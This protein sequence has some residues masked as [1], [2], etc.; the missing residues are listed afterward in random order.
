MSDQLPLHQEVLLLALN[1]KKG[2]FSRGL[3]LYSVTGA[4]VSELLLL[5]RIAPIEGKDHDVRVVNSDPTGDE[6]LD[7]L[8]QQIATSKKTRSLSHWVSQAAKMKQLPHRVAHQ[9][10]E[11]GIVAEDKKKVLWVFTQRIYP[12]LDG[13]FE[14]A[15]RDRMANIMFREA[16]IPDGRT[17]VL[18]ALARHASLLKPN[19]ASAELE[20][21]KVRINALANGNVLASDATKETIKAVQAA[22]IVATVVPAI[23]TSTMHSNH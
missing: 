8:L 22:I 4:M 17:A 19:F 10:A 7:E 2:T 12:E 13:T 23:V 14:D 6:I 1:D 16:T 5:S 15:I 20:Q 9:L 11:K 18:I 21:H 3:F